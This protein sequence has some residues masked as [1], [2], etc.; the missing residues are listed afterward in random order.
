[1]S[2]A[3]R[4]LALTRGDPSGIGLEIA[5]KAWAALHDEPGANPFILVED[6]AHAQRAAARLGF[7][8]PMVATT[9]AEAATVFPDALPILPLDA[10]TRGV[11][12]KPDAADAPGTIAS[13]TRCVELVAAGRASAVVTLPI[14]KEVLHRVGF[15]HPGHTEFMGELATRCFGTVSPKPVMLLWSPELAVVPATI[16][17]PLSAVPGLVTGA[18]IVETVRIVARD[19]RQRFGL[20]APRIAVAGLNPHASEGG[21]IGR[22]DIDIVAPALDVLRAEGI[23]VTGPHPADTLFHASARARYDVAVTM[24]HDQGLIPIKTLAFD[25]GVNVTLGLPFVRTSPDHGTAFDIAGRGIASEASLVAAL[26]LAARL[27]AAG[28]SI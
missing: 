10:E 3:G 16:H 2:D 28:R 21:D 14:S 27:A 7:D 5:L 18:L 12:G 20:A 17:V 8:V 15:A 6:V 25:T 19:M 4:P 22:E 11:P 23:A 9:A 24:Y 1:M 26:R 13:M